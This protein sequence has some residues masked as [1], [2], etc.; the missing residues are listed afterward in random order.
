MISHCIR[1]HR[2]KLF[3]VHAFPVF[4]VFL[5]QLSTLNRALTYAALIWP[6]INLL[7][8]P[9]YFYVTMCLYLLMLAHVYLPSSHSLSIHPFF[10]SRLQTFNFFLLPL[11]PYYNLRSDLKPSGQTPLT[12]VGRVGGGIV[13][14][15]FLQILIYLF[16]QLASFHKPAVKMAEM[17]KKKKRYLDTSKSWT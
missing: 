16:R 5:T 12:S 9:L 11:P 2:I 3:I 8:K 14:S 10:L 4:V 6:F 1:L 15:L 17:P 7:G 13:P